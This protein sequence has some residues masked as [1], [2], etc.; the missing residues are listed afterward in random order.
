MSDTGYNGEHSINISIKDRVTNEFKEPINTWT[1]WKLIPKERPY[2]KPPEVKEEYVEIPGMDGSLD[3]TELLS[4]RP[5]YSRRKG[6]WDFFIPSVLD[7]VLRD[8]WA[9]EYSK[10][11][12]YHGKYCKFILMDDP[13]FY[14][15]GRLKVNDWK[16]NKE[17]SEITFDY[18]LEPYKTPILTDS[19]QEWEWNQLFG[20]DA[21]LYGTFN[22]SGSKFRIIKNSGDRP[23]SIGTESRSIMRAFIY[24]S[25]DSDVVVGNAITIPSGTVEPSESSLIVQPGNTKIRFDGTGDLRL[26]YTQGRR[27]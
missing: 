21:I 2:V 12:E 1:N 17:R 13:L 24:A 16:T 9:S 4:G 14:Y 11:L 10:Y 27:L 6:S 23:V 19:E 20:L 22:V 7:G 3:Y 8:N 18:N 5:I 26:F 15:L 25:E